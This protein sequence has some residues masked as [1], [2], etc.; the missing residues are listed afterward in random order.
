MKRFG[1]YGSAPLALVLVFAPVA[2]AA[3]PLASPVSIT[4]KVM[5][6][7]RKAAADGTVK[8]VLAPAARVTPGDHVVYQV[9][10]Q[11]SGREVARDLVVANPV[12]AGLVYAGAAADSPEP[13][14][15]ID[16]VRF[17]ALSQLAVRSGGVSRAALPTDV[18]VVRW[19]I[20]S[21]AA[22]GN[23]QLSFRAKLK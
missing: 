5:V 8:I 16:G 11:N 2:Q 21:V 10:V 18:R 23:A 4:A 13:E 22:G 15:S 20:A 7:T 3:M 12:P 19:R 17:G 6:E 14:L 9:T 1:T